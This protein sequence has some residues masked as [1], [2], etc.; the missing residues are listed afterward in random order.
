M[1]VEIRKVN[2]GYRVQTPNQIHAKKTTKK[3]AEA[4]ARLLNTVEHDSDFV[5]KVRR[6][7]TGN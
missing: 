6:N 7:V 2:G 4:Q 1:P 5:K 3:K